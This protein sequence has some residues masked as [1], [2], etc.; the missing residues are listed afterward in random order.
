[1]Q[2]FAQILRPGDSVIEVGGHIGYFSIYFAN[3]VGPTG[4]VLVFEPGPNNLPYLR[5]NV[6]RKDNIQVAEMGV[7][8]RIGEAEFYIEDLTGQNNSYVKDFDRLQMNS[9]QAGIPVTV[10]TVKTPITT[11]DR[12]W[13][14]DKGVPRL[15]KIDVEG[16]EYAVLRG[17]NRLLNDHHP[18]LMVEVQAN[19]ADI[20]TYA[21]SL[22]YVICSPALQPIILDAKWRGNTFWFSRETYS[23]FCIGSRV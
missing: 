17:A 12:A 7:G 6:H 8:D 1:M 21:E 16:Y 5:H 13:P 22:D 20:Q 2:R 19:Q 3:L 11:L 23:N 9:L 14:G 18:I 4:Q 15:L 10:S